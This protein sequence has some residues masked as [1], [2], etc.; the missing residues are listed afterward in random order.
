MNTT[1]EH[2]HLNHVTDRDSRD[3][4]RNDLLKQ[5][6][7]KGNLIEAKKFSKDIVWI[8]CYAICLKDEH[9]QAIFTFLTK[10]KMEQFYKMIG[11]KKV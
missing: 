9:G 1:H 7:K 2:T 3:V 10:K 6:M 5:D 11:D 8:K 4:V